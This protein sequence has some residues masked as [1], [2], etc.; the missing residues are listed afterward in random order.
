METT[1]NKKLLY[2][3]HYDWTK[4]NSKSGLKVSLDFNHLEYFTGKESLEIKKLKLE[5]LI[6]F[7]DPDNKSLRKSKTADNLDSAAK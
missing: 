6:H 1:N 5:Q 4:D 7:L 2:T 3:V